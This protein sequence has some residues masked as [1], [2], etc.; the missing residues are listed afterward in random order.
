MAP[1]RS[2][3]ANLQGEEAI[4]ILAPGPGSRVTSP[5][6]VRG[7][8]DPTFEQTLLARVV[9]EDGTELALRPLTIQADLGQRGPFEV[10]VPFNVSRERTG[11]IQI[12][13][14]SARDGGILHLASVGVQLA[15]AGPV[16][17]EPASVQSEAIRIAQPV[18]GD[19]IAGGTVS[20]EG[21]GL[22]SFEGTLVVEIYDEVGSLVGSEPLIVAAPDMGR[23]GSFSAEVVYLVSVE[24][25]GR[26]VV[27]DPL[28]IFD[29]VGHIASVEVT[30]AP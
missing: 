6:R 25:P 5:V 22:A 30:L 16:R 12:F 20:V 2:A 28:P 27:V 11:L 19:R 3:A 18:T 17:I 15:P 10:E 7:V 26:I 9:L 29:G 23:P 1:T 8:A 13:H 21:V 14:R 4:L 24:G